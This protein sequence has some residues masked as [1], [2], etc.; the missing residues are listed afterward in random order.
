MQ[1]YNVRCTF[2]QTQPGVVP[3]S[4]LDIASQVSS[5]I[6]K[7]Q[8]E[9]E[10]PHDVP[11]DQL[12]PNGYKKWRNVSASQVGTFERCARLWF[13]TRVMRKEEP[14][15][16]H[17]VI[18]SAYHKQAEDYTKEETLPRKPFPSVET[19]VEE[20][21]IP[22]PHEHLHVERY[23]TLEML[24]DVLCRGYVDLI[25]ARGLHKTPREPLEVVDYKTA[26]SWKWCK[27]PRELAV[28]PQL[29]IYARWCL[30]HFDCGPEV[31]VRHVYLRKNSNQVKSVF[32]TLTREYILDRYREIVEIVKDMRRQSELKLHQV[33]P[34]HSACGMFGGCHFADECHAVPYE[35]DVDKPNLFGGRKMAKQKNKSKL[36][37]AMKRR[38]KKFDPQ[39]HADKLISLEEDDDKLDAY[40]DKLA[41]KLTDE[42]YDEVLDL[43]Y[44]EE[45]EEF[46]G[47]NPPDAAEDEEPRTGLDRLIPDVIDDT[48]T[49]NV[50][51]DAGIATLGELAEFVDEHGR[52]D[53]RHHI[54]GCGAKSQGI[55]L[56]A[57]D[58]ELEHADLVDELHGEDDDDDQQDDE[59]ITRSNGALT[60]LLV[61]CFPA[62]GLENTLTGED[63]IAKCARKVESELG[64]PWYA[65]DNFF[66]ARDLICA[67]A[68]E[69]SDSLVG[70][71]LVVNDQTPMGAA[72]LEVLT[73][74]ADV[75]V[76]R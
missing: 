53:F 35:P 22:P 69:K 7:A 11:P 16:I 25:D 65:L 19:A 44:E 6:D 8:E 60:V 74:L 32:T 72:L 55:I 1:M 52:D 5:Y 38:K 41:D 50:L 29:I 68:N 3:V 30:L 66:E 57:L 62:K 17:F 10:D 23:I 49:K 2:P 36:K 34:T 61:N 18:G 47:V 26:S 40:L 46:A 31:I 59:P 9:H 51:Q 54:D 28:D 24:D 45:E 39:K 21:F 12:G 64:R 33:E 48:R 67:L 58:A 27:T 15:S 75:V 20:G 71:T 4:S 37:D 43:W 14:G 73:P 76:K 63:I 42:Q 56:D 13:Y 70:R